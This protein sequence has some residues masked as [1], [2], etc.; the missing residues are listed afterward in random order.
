LRQRVL[1]TSALG[2][3]TY[4][5]VTVFAPTTAAFTTAGINTATID[6]T[7]LASVLQG[8]LVTG[9]N[10]SSS[11]SN[12]QSIEA[13]NT[14]YILNVA[15]ASAAVSLDVTAGTQNAGVVAVDVQATN[16]VVHVINKVLLLN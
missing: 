12:E 13:L 6:V 14:D 11:L 8:H 16:G 9:N 5:P 10:R 7:T 2:S 1:I 4:G 3:A 15:I